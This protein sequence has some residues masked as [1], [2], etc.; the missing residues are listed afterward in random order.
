MA[1]QSIAEKG[2]EVNRLREI[3]RYAKEAKVSASGEYSMV[4]LTDK[5]IDRIEKDVMA[6][7]MLSLK[8]GVKRRQ[9]TRF[10][11]TFDKGEPIVGMVTFKG[12]V[13]VAT[14]GGV[15]EVHK[16]YPRGKKRITFEVKPKRKEPPCPQ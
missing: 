6:W 10:I 11:T 7:H 3:L 12:K 16:K 8:G 15:Y 4:E 14:T 13:L 9:S 2:E 1:V 5:T